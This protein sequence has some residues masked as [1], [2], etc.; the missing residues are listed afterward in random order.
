MS[1]LDATISMLETMPEEARIRVYEYT[2]GLFLCRRPESPFT[3]ITE[4]MVLADLEVSTE[5]FEDG[6]GKDA[7]S[8]ILEM[9]R[10]HGFV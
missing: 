6:K 9:R 10:Q 5:E 2:K 1:T 7:K 8:T 4:E 3:S